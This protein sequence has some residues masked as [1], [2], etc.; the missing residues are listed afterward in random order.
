MSIRNT[1]SPIRSGG[2]VSNVIHQ[3]HACK[4]PISHKFTKP[5]NR[6][7][8]FGHASRACARRAAL[9]STLW[10]WR[11]PDGPGPRVGWPLR[12]VARVRCLVR[13]QICIN[14]SQ[15][16]LI[17]RLFLHAAAAGCSIAAGQPLCLRDKGH[18]AWPYAPHQ[19][20]QRAQGLTPVITHA[21]A[22]SRYAHLSHFHARAQ[23]VRYQAQLV[24]RCYYVVA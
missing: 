13:T 18:K 6:F 10:C 3:A 12:H 4:P 14:G 20:R 5:S 7:A 2:V 8:L 15:I 9:G 19:A 11:R 21:R 1:I 22:R 24:A 17:L 23:T 16:D